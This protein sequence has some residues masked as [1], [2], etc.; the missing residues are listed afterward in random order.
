MENLSAIGDQARTVRGFAPQARLRVD[1]I[2]FDSPYPRPGRDPRNQGLFG[3][4]W[5]AL[6]VKALA[7]AGVS[8][9]CFS[10]GPG[11]AYRAV[12]LASPYAGHPM[13]EVRV[14]SN[15]PAPVEAFACVSA[16]GKTLWIINKT[17]RDQ[18]VQLKGLGA[19]S[20]GRILRLN[21]RT[22]GDKPLASSPWTTRTGE[23]LL[24]LSAYEV[25]Q[26]SVGGR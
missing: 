6:A 5:T 4:A 11:R 8:E 3:D 1:P 26:V 7:D 13:L 10:V 14:V 16:T 17:D 25:C 2:G 21:E 19:N 18:P 20:A 23:M 12:D 22:T 24:R 15:H 9:A